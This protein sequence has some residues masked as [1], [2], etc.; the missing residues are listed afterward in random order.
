MRESAAPIP[1]QLMTMSGPGPAS[2]RRQ[3]E[4]ARPVVVW[5]VRV[6]EGRENTYQPSNS[7]SQ[8]FSPHVLLEKASVSENAHAHTGARAELRRNLAV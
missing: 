5:G 4:G 3:A 2:I 6:G 1:V 8:Y 7:S